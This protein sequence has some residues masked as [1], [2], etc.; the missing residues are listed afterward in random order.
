MR[1]DGGRMRHVSSDNGEVGGEGEGAG[2]G[3]RCGDVGRS[4]ALKQSIDAGEI[5]M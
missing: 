3:E 4:W 1:S 5:C 2:E